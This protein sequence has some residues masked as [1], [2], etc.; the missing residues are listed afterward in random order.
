MAALRTRHEVALRR[1]QKIT[2]RENIIMIYYYPAVQAAIIY[3]ED[4]DNVYILLHGENCTRT[5]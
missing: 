3:P 4:K 2:L 1:Q 5:G